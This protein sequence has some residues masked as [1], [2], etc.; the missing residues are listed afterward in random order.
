M[1]TKK[2]SWIYAVIVVL[3][4]YLIWFFASALPFL[5]FAIHPFSLLGGEKNY[6][7][8]FQN[9]Y[10]LRPTG[11]FI[12]SFGIVSLKNGLPQSFSFED[13]YGA[14]DDH[15]YVAPP[16]PL[17][18]LLAHKSYGGHSFR[19]ANFSP[20]FPASVFELE[21][22]LKKTRPNMEIDGAVALDTSFLES[23][24]AAFGAVRVSDRK[25][26][27]GNFFEKLEA[28]VSDLDLHDLAARAERKNIL[29]E[30]GAKMALKSLLPWNI[31]KTLRV[32]GQSFRQK[33]L[34]V[35]F[36]DETLQHIA[37]NKNWAGRLEK[38]DDAD[39]L[40]VVDANYGGG[41]SN[42]YVGRSIFYYIDLEK[43]KALLD[44]RYENPNTYN[45]PLST[46]YR[47]YVRA[48]VPNNH[49][50]ENVEFQG[51]EG[52]FV[53]G[54]KTFQIP[55]E[56]N[57]TVSMKFNFPKFEIERD[58]YS[59]KLWKQPGTFEDF[60]NVTVKLPVGMKAVSREFKTHENI[61]AFE[62]FLMDDFFLELAIEQDK[63]APRVLSQTLKELNVFEVE[64]NENISIQS[65]HPEEW[66]I[67]DSNFQNPQSDYIKIVNFSL[68]RTN[69]LRLE[70]AGMSEQSEERYILEI[71]GVADTSGNATQK[72]T[73]TFFQ[74]LE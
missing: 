30:L 29:R 6:L 8:L 31:P 28:D 57:G 1:Y 9:N 60:Y 37:E 26:D 41:K 21:K 25:F 10:E 51:S 73:Y 70:T 38:P 23:W 7:V 33:H 47:G 48:F 18:K 54:G 43:G 53:F 66:R 5:R 71:S 56:S 65:L 52:D 39:F 12:S 58:R 61:A 72:R 4:L 3:A 2:R 14:V 27:T 32:A 69:L 42:R 63:T 34:L 64:W 35:Y 74:R 17:G 22:F 62:G 36:K 11:G 46:D 19:D 50:P 13:V 55:I 45:L 15:P 24:L 20:D 67:T 40:A 49:S 68:P 16:E 59:L 44:I